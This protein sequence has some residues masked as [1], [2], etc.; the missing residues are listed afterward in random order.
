MQRTKR[1]EIYLSLSH[2]ELKDDYL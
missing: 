2:A 1:G